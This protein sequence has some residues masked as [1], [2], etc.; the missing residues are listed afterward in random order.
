[1]IAAWLTNAVPRP[2]LDALLAGWRDVTVVLRLQGAGML[3][4]DPAF[5]GNLRRSLGGALM[6]SASDQAQAR[7][8]CPWQPPCALDV[9]YR[10]QIRAGGDG[11]PKPMVFQ[12]DATGE[13]LELRLRL[14]GLAGDWSG[15]MAEALVVALR[16]ILPWAKATAGRVTSPPPIVGRTLEAWE[17][18][19][20][21]AP[22]PVSGALLQLLTPMD[23]T[24]DDWALR[25]ATVLTRALRRV[26]ALA[27]WSGVCLA[28]GGGVAA[29]IAELTHDTTGL[30]AAVA[31]RYSGS[32]RTTVSD[33][34]ITGNLGLSG[35]VQA[36][37]PLLTLIERCGIGRGASEG[38]GRARVVAS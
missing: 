4:A 38:R 37:W 8:P 30:R 7:V 17:G 19:E 25:P 11:M 31:P 20:A 26:D 1:M 32:A 23:A 22:M 29:Q 21:E 16:E 24:G 33:P 15:A 27:R 14:F 10:E 13:D 28:D 6:R 35:D 36:I 3:A 34:S 9:F 18:T 12:M 5:G 2:G